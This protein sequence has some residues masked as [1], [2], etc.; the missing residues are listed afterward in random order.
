MTVPNA[1]ERLGLADQMAKFNAALLGEDPLGV[2][3]R[4]HIYIEHELI[5]FIRARLERP[6]LLEALKLDYDGKVKLGLALGLPEEFGPAL[7]TVGK[8]R[9]GFAHRLEATIGEQE[10]NNLK[11]ALGEEYQVAL[12]N[13][14]ATNAKLNPE[15][16]SLPLSQRE[17]MDQ[18][19]I[20]LLVLWSGIAVASARARGVGA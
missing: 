14:A 7:S 10:A 5:G 11:K 15:E 19:I 16:P 3:V 17:P 1:A 8:L 20:Y 4:A 2:V 9:N 6:E 18:I 12:T 13:Y